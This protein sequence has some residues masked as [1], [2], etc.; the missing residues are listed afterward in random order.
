VEIRLPG[1]YTEGAARFRAASE[2]A[3]ATR[4][5]HEHQ[6]HGPDGD[7]LA[8]DIARL[9]AAD[10]DTML[11]VMSGTHGVEGF[12]GSACQTGWLEHG[13]A[14]AAAARLG[15]LLVHALNPYG[16]AWVRRVNEDNV[17]LN[18]NCVDFSAPLPENPGYDE[19]ADA[20][21]PER[22]DQETQD[23]TTKRILDYAARHGFPALQAAISGGQYRHPTG[24][25]YGGAKPSW[26]RETL[27]GIVDNHLRGAERVA[28]VDLHTGLGPFGVGELLGPRPMTPTWERARS[29]YGELTTPGEA[30]SVSAAVSG[31]V[32]DGIERRLPDHVEYTPAAIEWGTVDIVEVLQAL[33][34]DAWL[35]AYGDPTDRDAA[36]IKAAL[37]AAF[38]P[39]DSEWAALVGA[40]FEEVMGQAVAGLAG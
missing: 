18:R 14:R 20:V 21:V 35:H 23:V 3:G 13:G 11:V 29:W 19:L 33:R 9:G 38:A 5:R 31:D 28:V 10:A 12:A 40:R 15:V 4:E 8:I 30:E 36:P 22:W 2:A 16:F 37:R 39:D 32:L 24:L 6:L 1:S 7:A 27:D 26:S 34:G 25:F 17:D